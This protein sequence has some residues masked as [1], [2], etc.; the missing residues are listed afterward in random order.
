VVAVSTNARF[1]GYASVIDGQ[2]G[3]PTYLAAVELD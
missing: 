3:D 1:L 2:S